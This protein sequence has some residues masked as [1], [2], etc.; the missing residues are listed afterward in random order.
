MMA[1]TLYQQVTAASNPTPK[2]KKDDKIFLRVAG[3]DPWPVTVT[4][5]SFEKLGSKTVVLV[6]FKYNNGTDGAEY[7][8]HFGKTAKEAKNSWKTT[9]SYDKTPLQNL[10]FKT[11]LKWRDGKYKTW[12]DKF[13][14]YTEIKNATFG[15]SM[16]ALIVPQMQGHTIWVIYPRQD[17]KETFSP[18][19]LSAILD[20]GKFSPPQKFYRD[21]AF[22]DF[23]AEETEKLKPVAE[24]FLA[25]HCD[26]KLVQGS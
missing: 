7:E 18:A 13:F 16:V 25:M 1:K 9:G 12:D 24:K 4:K 22:K 15:S 23:K 5:N 26:S 17:G 20:Q 8:N 6:H 21:N 10:K 11:P 19:Q 3:M 14:S 2:Y